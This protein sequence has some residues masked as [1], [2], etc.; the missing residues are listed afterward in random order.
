VLSSAIT[1]SGIT[2]LQAR[3][4]M[5]YVATK[6]KVAYIHITEGATALSD[7]RTDSST[8]KLATYL[9]T[10]FLRMHISFKE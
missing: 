2:S 6:V 4:Y 8:A 9:L 7:G 3:Q 5:C 10:D 1:P